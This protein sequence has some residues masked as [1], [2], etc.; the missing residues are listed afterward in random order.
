MKH[1]PIVLL[2]PIFLQVCISYYATATDVNGITTTSSPI[3]FTVIAP[4]LPSLPVVSITSPVNGSSFTAGS[5]VILTMTATEV[6]GTVAIIS[7]YTGENV[8]V[9]SN[10]SSPFNFIDA[11]LAAGTYTY[12]AIASQNTNGATAP[13][14]PITFTVTTPNLPSLPV[15]AI[16]SPV[17]GSN[18]KAASNVVFTAN[19]S[20]VGGSIANVKYYNGT[21][22][23]GSSTT[24][25]YRLMMINMAAGTYSFT[26]VA[27]DA[28]GDS[29]ASSPIGITLQ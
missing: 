3:T 7:L 23:F 12:Y 1:P 16:T 29:T 14:A 10:K 19:A 24:S 22:L 4:V 15:V 26:A 21:K 20:E 2:L 28:R 27:T 5:N 17:D 8:F 13:S 11:N 25:P 9:G 6:G 18:L